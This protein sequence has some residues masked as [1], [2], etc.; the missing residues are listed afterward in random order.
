MNGLISPNLLNKLRPYVNNLPAIFFFS[1]P[2]VSFTFPKYILSLWVFISFFQLKIDDL[3][4]YIFLISFFMFLGLGLFYSNFNEGIKQLTKY[5]GFIVLPIAMSNFKSED[6]KKVVYSYVLGTICLIGITL[7]LMIK[8][9]KMLYYED[10][11]NLV[12]LHPGYFSLIISV[13]LFFTFSIKSRIKIFLVI[14]QV[15]ML[16]I[17]ESRML[18]LS[19]I[20]GLVFYGFFSLKGLIYKTIYFGLGL[21]FLS[22]TFYYF[23]KYDKRSK[24]L[25]KIVKVLKTEFEEPTK[26]NNTKDSS[27]LFLRVNSIKASLK[28]ITRDFKTTIFGVGIGDGMNELLVEYERVNFGPGKFYKY[29]S[30][31]Q[32]LTNALHSGVI[33]FFLF[34][35]IFVNKYFRY[36]KVVICIMI[37]FLGYGL[38]ESF[39]QREQGILLFVSIIT[40]LLNVDNTLPYDNRTFFSRKKSL[41]VN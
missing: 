40:L 6:Y 7:I 23:L 32:Y 9:G 3:K 4:K 26:V 10:L 5:L 1:I 11:S 37:L 39:L 2:F 24:D 18:I 35:L 28:I 14:V 15:L 17:L 36:N 30:H 29:N 16:S 20:L 34:L 8:G 13:A 25:S 12:R 27:Y 33:G 41:S 38:T 19:T 31:N 21:V 22:G